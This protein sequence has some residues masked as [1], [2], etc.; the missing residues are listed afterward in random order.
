MSVK[1]NEEELKMPNRDFLVYYWLS[2]N[3]ISYQKITQM[4]F[5]TINDEREKYKE[6]LSKSDVF[7]STL[8]DNDKK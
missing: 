5:D 8:I 4:L 1:L 3:I 6:Q 2:K 7:V